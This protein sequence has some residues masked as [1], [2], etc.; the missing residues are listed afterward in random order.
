MVIWCPSEFEFT[1]FCA[2]SPVHT[3]LWMVMSSAN[4]IA[5]IIIMVVLSKQ[6]SSNWNW[7]YDVCGLTLYVSSCWHW[8]KLI[9]RL[10][11]TGC[12][13]YYRVKSVMLLCIKAKISELLY[14]NYKERAGGLKL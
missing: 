11:M 6:A 8:V 5:T 9:A 7:F 12:H 3:L 1:L 2:Y 10:S 13:G 4:W 14:F